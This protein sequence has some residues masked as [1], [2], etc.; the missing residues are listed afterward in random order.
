MNAANCYEQLTIYSPDNIDYK[1]YY[2]QALYQACLYE[3]AMKGTAQIDDPD[4]HGQV[5]RTFEIWGI[6]F[7]KFYFLC[8]CK[9]CK[10]PSNME[11]RTWLEPRV[12]WISAQQMILTRKSTEVKKRSR[13]MIVWLGGPLA[14]LKHYL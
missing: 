3:E 8:R 9:S 13:D 5:L 11:K 7:S 14:E 1:V 10:Q 6:F 2:A 4:L 12:W